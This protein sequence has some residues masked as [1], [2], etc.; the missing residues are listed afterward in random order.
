MSAPSGPLNNRHRADHPTSP[1]R[2]DTDERP[3][4]A[5]FD[6][7][8]TLSTADSL[9]AFL[10]RQLGTPGWAWALLRQSPL[11]LA[12]ALR[13]VPNHRAKAALLEQTL[14]GCST[15]ALATTAEQL[16]QAWLPR[17]LN[18][19][20]LDELQAHQQ[21]GHTCVLLSASLDIYL[22]AVANALSIPHLICTGMEIQNGLCTGRMSTP[23][24][25]GDEKWRRLQAWFSQQGRPRETW[26]LHAYGDTQGDLPVLRQAD[27]AWLR[28]RPWRA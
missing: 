14:H 11:L 18:P 10:H 27:Q 16:V 1:H 3:V 15:T 5:V 28:G 17:H 4:L 22:A 9:G 13:L 2:V 6:F 21:A 12:Y 20:A 23:N 25:H 7:D 24:C 8:G 26:A 19:W